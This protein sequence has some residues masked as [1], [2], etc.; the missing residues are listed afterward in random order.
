MSTPP[1]L[2]KATEALGL[3]L[4]LLV[5]HLRR[6][7]YRKFDLELLSAFELGVVIRNESFD[8]EIRLDAAAEF[9][10]RDLRQQ[11]GLLRHMRQVLLRD[12]EVGSSM[13]TAISALN[14]VMQE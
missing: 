14:S 8:L 5:Q 6:S 11:R 12:L 2:R 1:A 7:P 9:V 10:R 4:D 3:A 13:A